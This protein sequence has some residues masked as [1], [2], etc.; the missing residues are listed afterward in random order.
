MQS[1]I[2]YKI[3]LKQDYFFFTA[4]LNIILTEVSFDH[5]KDNSKPNKVSHHQNNPN[6]VNLYEYKAINLYSN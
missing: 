5:W 1:L 6:Y 4:I 2:Q 3:P